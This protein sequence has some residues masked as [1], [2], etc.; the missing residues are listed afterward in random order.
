[1]S[2]RAFWYCPDCGYK[3]LVRVF[4]GFAVSGKICPRC[5]AGMCFVFYME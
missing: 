2:E 5:E 1:M 4:G 3:E